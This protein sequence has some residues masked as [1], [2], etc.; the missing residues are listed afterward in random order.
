[1]R[2]G[3]LD[4]IFAF[5]QDHP[6]VAAGT[7]TF[8]VAFS[9]VAGNAFYAQSGTH[10]E[11]IWAT[12]DATFTHSVEKNLR[13]VQT[14]TIKPR[15]A[16]V[17]KRRDS[18]LVNVSKPKPSELVAA[19]QKAL[20][21][22]GDFDG[23]VDGLMGPV[24]RNAIKAYQKRHNFEQTGKPSRLILA[25]IEQDLPVA[26]GKEDGLSGLIDGAETAKRTEKFDTQL[27]RQIQ[28]GLANKGLEISVDGIFGSKTSAAIREFQRK[29]D[30]EVTGKPDRNVLQKL[31]K[32]GAFSQG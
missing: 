6:S 20:I 27:V 22:T 26:S 25:S 3:F 1:M 28:S 13:P 31:Q 24:T 30:I 18:D 17:P 29:H 11:P 5:V 7:M 8:A 9:L 23:T 19:V 4:P 21:S 16:P 14:S 15:M 10:P 2:T 32:I 12:R